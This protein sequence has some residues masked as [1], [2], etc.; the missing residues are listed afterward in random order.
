MASLP[1]V[2]R[3]ASRDRGRR[4]PVFCC[5]A[6]R[7]GGGTRRENHGGA[8][9]EWWEASSIVLETP[10]L[11]SLIISYQEKDGFMT[12]NMEYFSR[13]VRL[14]IWYILITTTPKKSVFHSQGRASERFYQWWWETRARSSMSSWSNKVKDGRLVVAPPLFCAFRREFPDLTSRSYICP[15]H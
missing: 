15:T 3:A 5:S 11:S 2:R 14:R 1:S 9:R 8:E 7:Q 4:V 6:A 12:W 10:C 13:N